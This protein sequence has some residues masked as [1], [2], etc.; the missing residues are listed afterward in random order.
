MINAGVPGHSSADSLGRLYSQL[1][2]YEPD[3]L[4]VYQGW[5]DIK[6]WRRFELRPER[7]LISQVSPY[8]P[9]SN[10]F[11][12]YQGQLDEFL[13]H[14]QMYVKIRNRYFGSQLGVGTEGIISKNQEMSD[15]YGRFGPEQFRLNMELIVSACKILGTTPI[16]ITQATLAVPDNSAEDRARINYEYQ[17]LTH[18]AIVAAFTHTNEIIKDIGARTG[19]QVIDAAA[20]LSGRSDL[21][22]DQ[23]HTTRL[24]SRELARLVAA[25]LEKEIDGA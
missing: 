24:G 19:T 12:S 9:S 11:M 13:S 14:S 25:A 6:F 4:L 22:S 7:P 8:D 20:K 3:I 23:V 17:Q 1:W 21:F 2:M 18:R 15:S 10:P 5:N 16:L